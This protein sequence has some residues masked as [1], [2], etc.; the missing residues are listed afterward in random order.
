MDDSKGSDYLDR[1]AAEQVARRGRAATSCAPPLPIDHEYKPPCAKLMRGDDVDIE[2]VDWLWKDWIAAGK[3]HLVA[4]VPGTGKTTLVMGLAAALTTGGIWP[5]G[6]RAPQGDVLIWTGEDGI[7]DTL[8]PRLIA[9]GAE[10]SRVG[11][12]VGVTQGDGTRPFDPAKDI[13]P[14]A[15][16][17]DEWPN[18]R[19]VI[20]DPLASAISGDSHKNTDVRRGLDPLINLAEARGFALI[21]ITHLSKGTQGRDPLER[22]VGSLAFGA[23]ARI[24]LFAAKVRNAQTGAADRLLVRVKSNLGTDGGG[25]TY[26]LTQTEVKR[27]V[28]ASHVLWGASVTGSARELLEA[29]DAPPPESG[30]ESDAV[31]FLRQELARGAVSAKD[32]LTS[33]K[34]GGLSKM[35]I[36][37]ASKKLGIQK[38]K[39]AMDGG[40][41]WSLPSGEGPSHEDCTILPVPVLVKSS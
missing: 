10:M 14:L 4:G 5:D 31:V 38:R 11:F 3:F 25:V 30:G 41:S 26:S 33:A 29:A 36:H 23:A 27:G 28:I 21:G 1:L 2:A 20:L 13:A 8:A 40:W 37:R 24:A 18:T 32:V 17:L 35:V 7:A 9:S 12:I 22:V 34:D 16:A 39:S 15:Q 6:T 19:M